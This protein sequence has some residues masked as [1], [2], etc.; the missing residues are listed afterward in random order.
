MSQTQHFNI[1]SLSN[2]VSGLGTSKDK[3][4]WDRFTFMPHIRAEIDAAYRGDWL[5]RKIV[6]I[7][8][9]DMAREWREWKA[10]QPQIESIENEEK[11][12]GVIRKTVQ[13]LTWSRLY[14]GAALILGF[15]DA[16][17]EKPAPKTVGRMGLRYLHVVNRFELAAGPIQRDIMDEYYGEPSYWMTYSQ[18]LGYV[19]IHPSRVIP[20]IGAERADKDINAEYWGDST[21]EAIYDA[22]HNAALSN[23]GIAS[24]IHEAKLDVVKIPRLSEQLTTQE[25]ANKLTTRFALA[26]QMKGLVNTLLLDS[27][28]EW[29][30]KQLTFA[31][32]PEVMREFLQ[33]ACGAGDIPATRLLGMSPGG[34][35]STGESDLRNYYDRIGADQ[36]IWLGPSLKRLDDALIASALGNLPQDIWYDW[37]PLWQQSEKERAETDKLKSETTANYQ[38]TGLIPVDALAKGVQNRLEEDGTYPGLADAIEKS[39]AALDIPPVTGSEDDPNDPGTA[40]TTDAAPRTLYVRRDVKNASEI[41]AW[42]KEQGFSTTIKAEDLHVTIAFSRTPVDW[43]EMGE[44]WSSDRDGALTIEPGGPR[45]ID[46]LGPQ[47]EAIVLLFASSTLSW[48]HEEIV[49]KGASWDWPEYQPHITITWD[50][51]DIDLSSVEPYRGKIV[52]GP[53]IFEEVKEDWRSGIEE[54]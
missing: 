38:K 36:K 16:D 3:G 6:N 29:N 10:E 32:M 9:F 46:A 30:Q 50:K 43:M 14:G 21:L 28:E 41:I 39:N 40:A 42:A 27:E 47:G 51:G 23:A 31:N 17:P 5:A 53:E 24:M 15:G 54:R 33:V 19:K 20:F 2:V 52:L 7:P 11:R 1:D 44:N 35:N 45:M 48:R 18:S 49:R 8:P 37:A 25:Y 13:G 22:V 4:V 26:N 34:M 12:L